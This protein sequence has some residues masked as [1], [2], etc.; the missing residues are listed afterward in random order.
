MGE[1]V[2][3]S[4]EGEIGVMTVNNPPVNALSPGVPEGIAQGIAEIENDPALKAGILIGEGQTFIAGAD[5]KQF[6]KFFSG[7]AKR[8]AAGLNP[9]ING[10][11][12]CS[13]PIVCAIHGTAFGGGLEFAMGCHYRIAVASAQVGQPEVKLGIIPG[14]GGTQ[15]LP[16][17]A[18]VMKAVEMCAQGDPIKADEA[19]KLGILDRVL[20]DGNLKEGAIAYAKELIAEGKPPRRTRDLKDKLGDEKSNA[21]IF[22]MARQM[23]QQKA[24]GMLAPMKAID[25]V[26]AATKCPFDEGLVQEAKCFL[27]C[28]VSPQSRALIHVFFGE[29]AVSKIP[30]LPKDL[31]P[32]EI[33]KAAIIGAGTM[34]GGIAMAYANA[35]IPVVVKEAKQEFL[36]RGMDTIKKNYAGTVKKGK[37][38][39][40]KMDQRL[41]AI[42]PTLNYD[43]F[44]DADI[45]VE[46][47]FEDLEVKR[48]VFKELDKVCKPDCIL[49]TNTSTLDIDKMA[50]VTSRPQQVI[51]HHFFS[52]ANVMRLLEIVRGAKTSNE[53]I[54]TSMALA[55]KLKKVGVLVGNCFGFVGN[56][57]VGQYTRE[58]QFLLEEGAKPE[59]VDGALS[60]FGMA[61]GPLAMSD[62]AG[63]DVGWRVRQGSKHLIPAGQRQSKIVDKLYELGRYGQ[64][65]GKGFYKY[66]AG[67]RKPVPDP[68]VE[69]II[70]DCAKEA[71]IPRRTITP[72][73]II[74]RTIYALI[75]E[76]AN[77]LDEEIALRAVDI[78]IIYIFGYGF[79]PYRGGPMWYA[80]DVGLKKVYERVCE[81]EKQFGEIWKP[82][83]LLKKL[84]EE[85]KNF[86]AFDRAKQG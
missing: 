61:M 19:L 42:R 70:E 2:T 59:D 71:G 78:D 46:A 81:F 73:E 30:G 52:P 43:D 27:E 6:G 22:G 41:A 86:E 51:G 28:L 3:L 36:D 60:N 17:L 79:P 47:A 35:G 68:E 32:N 29:R 12:S 76:G 24:R 26:E 83:P 34:G 48:A 45:V 63:V 9:I 69:K 1:L 66:N 55:K 11:E 4:K 7:G 80:N 54:A 23:T 44:K 64:K 5:I 8:D 75:N 53:V 72:E 31:K 85:G 74:E 39:Q 82:A 62:L 50:E 14:A 49:A 33:K 10:I 20:A 77:I 67:D 13:K 40:E 18:G 56:R 25:A 15:R 21:M 58:A 38:T 16:R 57:M 65:T 37:L 84:A